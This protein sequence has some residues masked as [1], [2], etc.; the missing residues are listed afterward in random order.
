MQIGNPPYIKGPQLIDG[1]WLLAL[2]GGAN[3]S[4][5]NGLVADTAGTKADALQIEAGVAFVKFGTVAGANDA[6]LLPAAKAGVCV[7]VQNAGASTMTLFGT[8]TDTINLAATATGYDLTTGQC[9]FFFCAE[10]GN[11]GAIKTA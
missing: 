7:C 3:R 10:D 8:G 2:A 1:N 4:S 6:A 11:W 9:A 5:Q